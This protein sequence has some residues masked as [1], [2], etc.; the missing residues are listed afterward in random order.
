MSTNSESAQFCHLLCSDLRFSQQSVLNDQCWAFGSGFETPAALSLV[1]SYGLRAIRMHIFPEFSIDDQVMRDPEKFNNRPK[2]TFLSTCF[3]AVSFSPFPLL[4][5]EYRVWVPAPQVVVGQISCSNTSN[6]NR[7]IGVDWRI[8]LQP[9][10]HGSPMKQSQAGLNTILQG[11]CADLFP[12][13]YLTGGAYP[14]I[15]NYPGLGNKLHLAPNGVRQVTWALASLSTAEASA[16]ISRQYSSSSLEVEQIKIEM[17]DRRTKIRCE[18]T[19]AGIT[20]LI[21][22]SQNHAYQLV[23]MPVRQHTYPTYVAK[24]SP[25]TGNYHSE[26]LLE[27][28]PEWSGQTLTEIYCLAQTL[29]PGR[30]EVVKGLLQNFLNTQNADGSIDRRAS[31][32]HLRSGHASLPLLSS[33]AADL[34][35]FLEDLNWLTT[36][37]PKLLAFLK[38]WLSITESGELSLSELSNPVQLD[39]VSLDAATNNLLCRHWVRLKSSQNTF[40]ISLLLKET[41]DLLQIAHWISVEDDIDW[42]ERVRLQL[43][44]RIKDLWNDDKS[45]YTRRDLSSAAEHSGITLAVFSHA[46]L[47]KIK[48]NLNHPGEIYVRI[49]EAEKLPADFYC[50]LSGFSANEYRE[51]LIGEKDFQRIGDCHVYITPEAYSFIESLQIA[52]LPEG[53]HGE[54]GM[55]DLEL[56]DIYGLLPLY[57]GSPSSEQVK[58]LLMALDLQAFLVEGGLSS[59]AAGKNEPVLLLPPCFT[60]M[61]I[62][63]LIRY[64]QIEPAEMIFRHCFI[65][66]QLNPK[67][68]AAPSTRCASNSI[69][70]LFPLR[71]YLK[72]HGLIKLTNREI[73]ISHNDGVNLESINVQYNLIRLEIKHHLTEVQLQSGEKV[74][75]NQPGLNR[76]LLE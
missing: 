51:L 30:P 75:L 66:R 64:Q 29:L 41:S 22:Q 9:I 1:T 67:P 58:R 43:A 16:Q 70:E 57:C 27:I 8:H 74:Y 47:P 19:A 7:T 14:S 46:G 39:F 63:G 35:P 71:T 49:E 18:S 15:S 45:M 21:D 60:L 34:H 6:F 38:S 31:A 50:R 61:I 25:D 17:A 56:S 68:G 53:A 2:C 48:A 20:D 26:D 33:L 55:A 37:Y 24:R 13:F 32:N 23:T 59:S 36:I 11:E 3:A 69:D 54:V 10:Q 72:L 73:L 42:L 12:S 4:D 76:V 62:E 52:H 5:V 40:L 28:H 44:E 65:D